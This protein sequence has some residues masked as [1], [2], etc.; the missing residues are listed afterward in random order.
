MFEKELKLDTEDKKHLQKHFDDI[1]NGKVK[2][3]VILGM[4]EKG[5][6]TIHLHGRGPVIDDLI[7]EAQI[8]VDKDS[9]T[10]QLNQILKNI[11]G[12]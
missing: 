1:L 12:D 6:I 5:N 11:L 8:Q 9:E 7:H 3:F 4:D 10:N 2:N